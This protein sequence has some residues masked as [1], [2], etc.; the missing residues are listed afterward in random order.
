MILAGSPNP[1]PGDRFYMSCPYVKIDLEEHGCGD[2]T[3]NMYQLVNQ[4][5][6]V[7]TA[8]FFLK[9]DTLDHP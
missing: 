8:N 5:G 6:N 4:S 7:E 3:L 2:A 9:L 1:S